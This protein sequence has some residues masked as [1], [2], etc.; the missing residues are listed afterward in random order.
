MASVEPV[1]ELQ[2]WVARYVDEILNPSLR[3]VNQLSSL[4]GSETIKQTILNEQLRVLRTQNGNALRASTQH[5]KYMEL[6]R[7]KDELRSNILQWL[8][9]MDRYLTTNQIV[10]EELI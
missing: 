6:K 4:H 3:E 10:E 8:D 5:I 2:K 7:F 1:L 9:C